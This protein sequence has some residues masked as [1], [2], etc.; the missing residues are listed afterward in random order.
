MKANSIIIS[1]YFVIILIFCGF[2]TVNSP[3]IQQKPDPNQLKDKGIGPIKVIEANG[4]R[5][6]ISRQG[7]RVIRFQ[8]CP[9]SSYQRCETCP[10]TSWSYKNSIT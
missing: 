10:G 6:E 3:L 7:K 1:A 5:S 9:M 4:S 2:M 8:M